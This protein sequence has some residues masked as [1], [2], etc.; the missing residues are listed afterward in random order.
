MTISNNIA[1]RDGGGL[2]AK[3]GSVLLRHATIAQNTALQGGGIYIENNPT[4]FAKSSI[5]ANNIGGNSD[6]AIQSR[7]FNIDSGFTLGLTTYGDM[8]N[9]NP[10]LQPLA[11]NGGIGWTHALAPNS[12]A[13]NTGASLDALP[14]DGRG[15]ARDVLPDIG[16]WE[17]V[18]RHDTMLYWVDASLDAIFR[19]GGNGQ[20]FQVIASGQATP[21]DIVVDVEHGK[22][23]WTDTESDLVQQANLDGTNVVTLFDASDGLVDPRGIDIDVDQQL[24]YF[25]DGG[26]IWEA[27]LSNGSLTQIFTTGQQVHGVAVDTVN[28]NLFWTERGAS[29]AVLSGDLTTKVVATVL[30]SFDGLVQPNAIDVRPDLGR[31]VVTDRGSF[32]APIIQADLNGGNVTVVTTS[33]FTAFGVT[34]DGLGGRL[35]WTDSF[36]LTLVGDVV[37]GGNIVTEFSGLTGVRG[38]DAVQI[39]GTRAAPYDAEI[40]RVTVPPVIDGVIDAG[41]VSTDEQNIDRRILGNISNPQDLSAEWKATW[42]DTHLYLLVTVHDED[43]RNNS[44][45]WWDDDSVEIFID[46]DASRG[47][48]YDG[49]N[50]FQFGF[51]WNDATLHYGPN[52]A[53]LTDDSVVVFDMVA[54]ADG[55][56][57]EARI[58]WA[59]L[60][61]TPAPGD[62]IGIEVQINDDD[63]GGL[64]DASIAWNGVS[65]AAY[66]DPSQFGVARLKDANADPVAD[67]GG[68]YVIDEGDDVLLDASLSSDPDGDGLTFRWDLDNDGVYD[69][70]VG[71]TPTIAYSTLQSLGLPLDLAN[72]IA[73]EISD[74]RG[75]VDYAF[76]TLTINNLAPI[77]TSPATAAVAENTTFVQDITYTDVELSAT[78]TFSLTGS[79]DDTL[80]Q[81][82]ASGRLEFKSAPDYESPADGNGD[83]QYVVTVTVTDLGGASSSLVMTV[84]VT[85]VNEFSVTAP[86]DV[87]A[88]VNQVNENLAAGQLVGLTVSATDDDDNDT[89]TYSLLDDAGGRFVIN[90]VTG[91]VRTNAVL[92]AELFGSHTIEVEALSSDGSTSSAF[93]VIDVIDVNESAVGPVT[94]VN[95]ALNRVSEGLAPGALVGVTASAVDSDVTDSVTYSLLD[96]AGG[97]FVINSVTGVVRTNAVL[98][99]EFSGSHTIE[100]EALSSDGSTSSA[101]FVIDVIDVNESAVGPVT[102][103]NGALNRVNEGLAPGAL[104]GVTAS[105]VDSDATDSVTYSLLDDAGGRFVIDSVTGVV[106]TNAVLDAEFSGSH[107]IEV[108]ALSSDGSTSSAFFVIDVIDVNESAVGSG[109][110]CERRLESS[111]R[112]PGAR[113]PG[114]RH[115]VR[116]GLRC[117]RQRHLFAAG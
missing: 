104:V 52:S 80:F 49:V 2:Y 88:A 102:D 48:S 4:F 107:T 90:S 71:A 59:D 84:T 82:D 21:I 29:P 68:P 93:F 30:N 99:A 110:R 109:H 61:V 66:T 70:E 87:N 115:R 69:D 106:R 96:D 13:I 78:A 37:Q 43:L 32:S 108:E 95:G 100:V 103:V 40:S 14:V 55:Y 62:D 51:R 23:Y 53:T 20:S 18:G 19:G 17:Y 97:R 3:D 6:S 16:A 74:G 47:T 35:F 73:V 41:W 54:T 105:A 22:I 34:Y 9:V 64:R 33:V 65:N 28:G 116:G 111:Q 10:R 57:L 63:G 12:A 39:E 1:S 60:G 31:I 113:R 76:S 98:D 56:V 44:S 91:V 94:D 5:F 83:N 25:A 38:V 26:V 67:I 101:F 112:R 85:P 7:G 89:V 117:D 50:D 86:V 58:P 79:D 8:A 42:D 36:A 92:D 27:D 15:V 24:L 11:D 77:I 114:G 46:A 81:I 75:G 45:N 72:P